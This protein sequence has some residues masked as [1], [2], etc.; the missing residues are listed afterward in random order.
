[1]IYQGTY[2]DYLS[3]YDAIGCATYVGLPK[4]GLLKKTIL[5]NSKIIR[6]AELNEFATNCQNSRS[7]MP[8]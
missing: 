7:E 2:D 5:L 3:I 4:L 8:Q 1:M 6:S